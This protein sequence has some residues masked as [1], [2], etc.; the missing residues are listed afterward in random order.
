[1]QVTKVDML[2]KWMNKVVQ[3]DCFELMKELPDKCFDLVLTDPPYGINKAEWDEDVPVGY[4][5]EC[6]R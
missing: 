1:M 2:H 6:F 5:K 4:I 3:G